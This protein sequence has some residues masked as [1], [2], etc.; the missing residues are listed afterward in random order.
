MTKLAL[1]TGCTAR[2]TGGRVHMQYLDQQDVYAFCLQELGYEVEKRRVEPG[3]DLSKYA[4]II[5]SLAPAASLGTG[6]IFG[7]LWTMVSRPDCILSVEDWRCQDIVG[8]LRGAMIKKH[9]TK[10]YYHGF[11]GPLGRQ[12]YAF[13]R[14]MADK[15]MKTALFE[16]CEKMAN[17]PWDHKLLACAFDGGDLSLLNLPAR[18]L[19]RFCYG[20]FY[21]GKYEGN[22]VADSKR[23]KIWVSASLSDVADK[24]MDKKLGGLDWPTIRIGYKAAGQPRMQEH[25]VFELYCKYWGVISAPYKHAKSAWYRDRFQLAAEAG[26]VWGCAKDEVDMWCDAGPYDPRDI[27]KLSLSQLKNLRD[28]QK[29]AI[30]AALPSNAK[31]I[32]VMRATIATKKAR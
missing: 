7:S 30:F 20:G 28:K 23:E 14:V 15:K 29:A 19:I 27:E 3:E 10:G 2:Q 11:D 6:Y 21:L 9:A 13:D 16:Q 31:L 5:N 32:E 12:R 4:V 22:Q 26:A 24:W 1:L 18:E 25:E 8:H 17:S